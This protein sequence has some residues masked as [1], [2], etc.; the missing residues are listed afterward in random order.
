MYILE[1][2]DEK[3]GYRP[4]SMEY[5]IRGNPQVYYD[6]NEQQL[7]R[8]WEKAKSSYPDLMPVIASI[9]ALGLKPYCSE[10]MIWTDFRDRILIRRSQCCTPTIAE[11][12]A[13]RI[14]LEDGVL[15]FLQQLY[16][17]LVLPVAAAVDT[18]YIDIACSIYKSEIDK[19]KMLFGT[20]N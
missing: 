15:A 9:E 17:T 4:N 20:R 13:D 16:F 5:R 3:I 12:I 1:V 6:Y 10:M 2:Q 8:D 14:K 19:L 18:G 11:H 7:E